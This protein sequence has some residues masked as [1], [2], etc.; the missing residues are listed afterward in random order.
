MQKREKPSEVIDKHKDIP[1]DS[2]SQQKGESSDE[3]FL[4]SY[5]LK[6]DPDKRTA[7]NAYRA[8]HQEWG[9]KAEYNQRDFI[10]ASKKH[11]WQERA[12]DKDKYIEEQLAN[13]NTKQQVAQILRFK[14]EQ[15]RL[16]QLLNST[17]YA[18]LEKVSARIQTL[19]PEEIESRDLAGFLRAAVQITQVG[20]DMLVDNLGLDEI[21]KAI[22]DETIDSEDQQGNPYGIESAFIVES[23]RQVDAFSTL[24]DDD[25]DE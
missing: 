15:F 13:Y 20:K 19:N 16:S 21:I 17:G 3:Y 4:F 7:A 24:F 5:Y 25:D 18:L 8:Y 23:N 11:N 1:L 10:S 9:I 22:S 2:W 12:T 14:E 6:L